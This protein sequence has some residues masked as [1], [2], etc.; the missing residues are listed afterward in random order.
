MDGRFGRFLVEEE[1]LGLDL[2][3]QGIPSPPVA[4]ADYPGLGPGDLLVTRHRGSFLRP[5]PATPRYN[6]CGLNIFHIGQGCDIGC[7]YCILSAYLGTEAV[8]FFGNSLDEGLDELS[9]HLDGELLGGR[10]WGSGPRSHRYCTGEFTDSLLLDHRTGISR[11]LVEL[12]SQRPP[13]TLELKTKTDSVRHLLGLD[14][15]GRTVISFSVNAPEICAREEP[16]AARLE[17]RLEAAALAWSR[18]YPIGLHFDP[19]VWF[20]GWEKGYARTVDLIARILDPMALAFVSMGCFRFLPAL[21]A[22]MRATRP[23]GLFEAEFVLGGDGK[24][25]YPR[26][27]RRLMYRTVLGLLREVVLPGT[28]IYLCME[29]GRVWR[30]VFGHDPGTAGLTGLF[31]DDGPQGA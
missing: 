3:D 25:R 9:R 26:P 27:R 11:R 18:G 30:E 20:P 19:L 15:G 23:S 4:P 5:C 28:R 2:G 29:S 14:H 24:M 31:R 21:K 6:C 22:I 10:D 13:F 7:S 17:A 12:F 1:F 16:R 8:I